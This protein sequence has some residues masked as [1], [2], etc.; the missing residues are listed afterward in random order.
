MKLNSTAG[1][2]RGFMDWLTSLH[3]AKPEAAE[4]DEGSPF[5]VEFFM[6]QGAGFQC[7]AYKDYD[8]KWHHAFNNKELPGLVHV[9]E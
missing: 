4:H 6:V 5:L 7:M 9:L 2:G 3:E 8:G 1:K